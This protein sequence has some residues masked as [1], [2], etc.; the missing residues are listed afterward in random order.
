MTLSTRKR[1]HITM[2]VNNGNLQNT[3]SQGVISMPDPNNGV[4]QLIIDS[5]EGSWARIELGRDT[6][7]IPRSLLP[8]KANPG[9]VLRFTIRVDQEATAK[10]RPDITQRFKKLV[11]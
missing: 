11:R 6:F 2:T 4:N 10:R 7:N 5:F 1:S 8:A 9:D 3:R